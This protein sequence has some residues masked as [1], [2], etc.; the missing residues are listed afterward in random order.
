M[1]SALTNFF[2]S[3]DKLGSPINLR[4]REQSGFGTNIGGIFSLF[5]T[6][7]FIFFSI[8]EV[9]GWAFRPTFVQSRSKSYL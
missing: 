6:L 5:L 2:Q 8:T 4:Y 3:N 1:P 9:F 7:C